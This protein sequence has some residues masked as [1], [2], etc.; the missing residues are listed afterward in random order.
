MEISVRGEAAP[1]TTRVSFS[2]KLTLAVSLALNFSH[3]CSPLEMDNYEFEIT[4]ISD[5]DILKT[6]F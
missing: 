5:M 6:G 1:E 4:L 3:A 2:M